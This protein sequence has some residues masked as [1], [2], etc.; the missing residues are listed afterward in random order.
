MTDDEDY[1]DPTLSDYELVGTPVSKIDEIL[2]NANHE[3]T[4]T[5][6]CYR[7]TLADGRQFAITFSDRQLGWLHI[8]RDWK[9]YVLDRFHKVDEVDALFYMANP[10]EPDTD[11][12]TEDEKAVKSCWKSRG[13]R[14]C[15]LGGVQAAHV[16]LWYPQ[17]HWP[18]AAVQIW[19]DELP[20]YDMFNETM[21]ED[22]VPKRGLTGDQI[23]RRQRRFGC[24]LVKD[25]GGVGTL[26]KRWEGMKG[27]EGM[28]GKRQRE[29]ESKL[30]RTGGRD[31]VV[32]LDGD[33]VGDTGRG[34]S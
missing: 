34:E 28:K 29:S 25:D 21:S 4:S 11:A 18:R 8:V 27:M 2:F 33:G 7:A 24:H 30:D 13:V 19:T 31:A 17:R 12:M 20:P 15:R 6:W 5:H 14:V 22:W 26:W 9:E 23:E 32:H 16:R 1:I 3:Y 10:K